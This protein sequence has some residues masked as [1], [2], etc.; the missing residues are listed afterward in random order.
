MARKDDLQKQC[1]NEKGRI[2]I[3]EK[4]IMKVA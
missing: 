3:M 1:E 4:L 2:K